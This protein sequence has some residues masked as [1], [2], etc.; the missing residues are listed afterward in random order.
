MNLPMPDTLVTLPN[1]V[2]IRKI[3]SVHFITQL[4]NSSMVVDD[5]LLSSLKTTGLTCAVLPKDA[6]F[7]NGW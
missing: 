4:C 6:F 3:I 5:R 1:R 7:T 2:M